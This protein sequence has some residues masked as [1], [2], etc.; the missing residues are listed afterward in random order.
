MKKLKQEYSLLVIGPS[1]IHVSKLSYDEY[2]CAM[3]NIQELFP[4]VIDKLKEDQS[5]FFRAMAKGLIDP[6][7]NSIDFED[8]E[9]HIGIQVFYE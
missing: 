1:W 4:L 9:I 2:S 6:E 7:D 5:E 3:N 8:I